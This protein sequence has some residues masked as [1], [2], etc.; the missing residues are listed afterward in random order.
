MALTRIEVRNSQSIEQA[1]I[2]LGRFTVPLARSWAS[3][4]KL[5]F[6]TGRHG[7]DLIGRHTVC[8]HPD[9]RGH[10]YA[11]APD[12]GKAAHGLWIASDPLECH[13]SMLVEQR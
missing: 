11:Q 4:I 10:R 8:D 6:N 7:E 1:S 9:D 3:E 13:P 2:P 12:A 5:S